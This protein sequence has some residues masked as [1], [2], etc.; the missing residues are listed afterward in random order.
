[1]IDIF[2]MNCRQERNH[3]SKTSTL[4]PP[5]A[6]ALRNHFKRNAQLC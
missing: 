1:M 3:T 6:T 4:H 2:S 5:V